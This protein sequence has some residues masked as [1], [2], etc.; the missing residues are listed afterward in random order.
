MARHFFFL[1][2]SLLLAGFVGCGTP[3]A[4]NKPDKGATETVKPEGGA[5]EKSGEKGK[6]EEEPAKAFSLGD[7]IKP[8][9]PPTLED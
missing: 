7:M 1:A 6:A 8:F 9:D 2:T 4:E 3:S 5:T